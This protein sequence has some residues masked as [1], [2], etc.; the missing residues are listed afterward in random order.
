[1]KT[2]RG[3]AVVILIAVAAMALFGP[4]LA[5]F[6]YDRQFRDATSAPPGGRFPLGTDALGR[7]R[8]S[9]LFYAS[10]TS[11]VLAP[12]AAAISVA[13]ALL[14][15]PLSLSR[16]SQAGRMGS[17]F[18]AA[19]S[20]ITTVCLALPWI[21][22][23]IILRA[24][25]PLDTG[26]AASVL[27]TFALMGVAGWAWPARVFSASIGQMERSGWMLHARATGMGPWRIALVHGWPQLR[28]VAIAQFR[29]LVPAYILAE[30]SLGLLGLG[31]A[32]PL[33]SWGN[34]LRDLQHP[35]LV[36][37]NPA[38]AAPLILLVIVMI[39]LEALQI[40]QSGPETGAARAKAMGE[41]V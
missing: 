16:V 22:L 4:A 35:D 10:R 39:C 29:I 20:M 36:R 34:L 26:P 8:L 7:D 40:G 18:R 2:V 5:P 19:I 12:A 21:F 33:P 31:V 32:E 25:L 11:I 9:R 17:P 15:A 41:P 1:M 37:A 13:L 6:P 30:A 28:A 24:E 27:I 14:I 3:M 23:F 38:I